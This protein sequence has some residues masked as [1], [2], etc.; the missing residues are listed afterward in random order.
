MKNVSLV[1]YDQIFRAL[2]YFFLAC[3]P[4][5]MLVKRNKPGEKIDM[6]AAH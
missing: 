4:L 3:V 2:G 1:T 6:N 5:I